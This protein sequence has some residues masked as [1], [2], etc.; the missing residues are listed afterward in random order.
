MRNLI[1]KLINES[2][3]KESSQKD[4][5]LPSGKVLPNFTGVMNSL[6]G[7]LSHVKQAISVMEMI[8]EYSISNEQSFVEP[9]YWMY[10]Y[11]TQRTDRHPLTKAGYVGFHVIIYVSDE[12][13]A[14]AIVKNIKQNPG[15]IGISSTPWKFI[16][17]GAPVILSRADKL[18]LTGLSE[19]EMVE[20]DHYDEDGEIIDIFDDDIARGY[21]RLKHPS[22]LCVNYSFYHHRSKK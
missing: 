14:D 11:E 8:P 20:K 17:T 12:E 10:L 6:T 5:V 1:R 4:L 15:Y 7:G 9:A 18:K 2:L 21:D 13:V 19:E 3:L 22:G 16:N